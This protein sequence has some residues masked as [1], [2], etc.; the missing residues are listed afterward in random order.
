MPFLCSKKYIFYTGNLSP[1]TYSEEEKNSNVPIQQKILKSLYRYSKKNIKVHRY[2]KLYSKK[3][4]MLKYERGESSSEN[5]EIRE[6]RREKERGES[7]YE[8]QTRRSNEV[9][10]EVGCSCNVQCCETSTRLLDLTRTQH[11]AN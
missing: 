2:R 5:V 4:K 8:K 11:K 7:S 3:V 10:F 1:Y 6:T 9:T